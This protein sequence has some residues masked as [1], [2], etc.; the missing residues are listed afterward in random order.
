MG[1]RL[2][3]Q[4]SIHLIPGKGNP[5]VRQRLY[6]VLKALVSPER[7]TLDKTGCMNVEL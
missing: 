6:L 3:I 5:W 2:Q 4:S 1:W 7:V